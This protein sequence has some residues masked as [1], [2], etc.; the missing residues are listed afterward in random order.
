[1]TPEQQDRA[2]MILFNMSIENT[3][4]RAFFRR[5]WIKDELLRNDA[6]QL[7][8]EIGYLKRQPFNTRIV[9]GQDDPSDMDRCAVLS[10]GAYTSDPAV[11]D[12][13]EAHT[14]AIRAKKGGKQ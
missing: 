11:V 4:W 6:G 7:I 2:L 5:W 14:A 10:S 12:E 13:W 8:R 9:G 3:G 1:M